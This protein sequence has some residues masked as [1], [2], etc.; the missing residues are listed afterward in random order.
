[1]VEQT[2]CS[3]THP[4][5]VHGTCPHC[6]LPVAI[7]QT[8]SEPGTAAPGLSW[9][10]AR[11]LEDLERDDEA[12][13]LT[14]I[15]NL[16]DQLPPLNEALPVVRKAFNDRAER[17]RDRA[18]TACVR[19]VES[20]QAHVT[21]QTC[22][23]LL[24]Q[25]PADL[26]ALH[27]LLYFYRGEHGR[28]DSYRESLNALILRVI[29]DM[30]DVPHSLAVPMKLSPEEDGCAFEQAKALWLK[31]V[32]RL[33][34]NPRVLENASVFFRFVD[35]AMAGKLLRR[36]KELDP[37]NARWSRE[38]GWLYSFQ[39]DPAQPESGKDWGLMSL[40]ELETA[41]RSATDPD[42]RFLSLLWIPRVCLNAG[43]IEKASDYAEELLARASQEQ[44][45]DCLDLAV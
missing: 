7:G 21:V 38:L 10:L 30:P 39:G 13:R 24:R 18:L 29:A 12:T 25:D 26:A 32:Q 45:R 16:S 28:S 14:T 23:S 43:E 1:M 27:V 41:W 3:V 35:E 9:N 20:T 2:N 33:P 44:S 19:L 40:A 42:D 31:Q 36:C 34:D 17:V 8:A 5:I 4:Q 37:G 22:E 15:H 11:M 6:G